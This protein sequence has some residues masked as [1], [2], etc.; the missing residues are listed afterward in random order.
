MSTLLITVGLVRHLNNTIHGA[1][2]DELLALY[3]PNCRMHY[4]ADLSR[5]LSPKDDEELACREC[6]NELRFVTKPPEH[7]PVTHLARRYTTV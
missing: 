1:R 5:Y 6:D 3:C 7:L 2:C 4:T